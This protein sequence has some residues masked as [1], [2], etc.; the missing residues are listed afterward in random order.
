MTS[1]KQ[2]RS[3]LIFMKGLTG[4]DFLDVTATFNMTERIFLDREPDMQVE[5]ENG[6][7][8]RIKKDLIAY[9]KEVNMV[10]QEVEE[11]D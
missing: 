7:R 2:V 3:R 8:L 6:D 4:M 11:V 9:I 5:D 1:K 10:A